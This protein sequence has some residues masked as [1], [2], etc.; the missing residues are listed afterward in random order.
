MSG[1]E[2]GR[3]L[4]VRPGEV[5]L[6]MVP[7]DECVE[8]GACAKADEGMLLEAVP[9]PPGLSPGDLV[10]VS[11]SPGARSRAR[12]LVFVVPVAALLLGYMAGFLLGSLL[13]ASSDMI[14]AVVG[15][16]CGAG[17]LYGVA[18]IDSRQAVQRRA[19]VHVHAI[20]AQANRPRIDA[21]SDGTPPSE[22]DQTRE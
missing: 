16:T 11:I 17:A 19:S 8:C 22:E 15:L 3:V 14:G 5:D 13:S 9:A 2:R 7:G 4:R 21:G 12:V 18:R 10:E 1:L 20:I 6:R